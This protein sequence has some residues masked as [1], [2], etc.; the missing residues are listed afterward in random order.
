PPVTLHETPF[1]FPPVTVAYKRRTLPANTLNP[2]PG[3]V[4]ATDAVV[5]EAFDFADAEFCARTSDGLNAT[6]A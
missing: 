4:I 1:V 6:I 3:C 5:D 2:N